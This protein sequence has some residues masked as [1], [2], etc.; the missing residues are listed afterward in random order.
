[1]K[2]A[3]ILVVEDDQL[4]LKLLSSK[5]LEAGYEV[6]EASNANEAM[7]SAQEQKPDLMIL[8]LTL[9]ND[10]SIN[11]IIDGFGLLHW[12]RYTLADTDFPVIVHT[13]DTSRSIDAKAGACKVFAVFR[14]GDSMDHLLD[15]V[16]N[17]LKKAQA[18]AE[19]AAFEV[20]P[21]L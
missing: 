3:R 11:G 9:V 5:L 8:D 18:E 21:A 19:S 10:S 17:A 13:A 2:R 16:N 1:M 15:E 6:A 14:K 20:N 7:H 4:V 12:L